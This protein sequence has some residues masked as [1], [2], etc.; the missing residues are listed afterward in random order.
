MTKSERKE[1]GNS[2]ERRRQTRHADRIR[3][4]TK[5]KVALTSVARFSF[6]PNG[7][8]THT[9]A[10]LLHAQGA[11]FTMDPSAHVRNCNMLLGQLHRTA[12]LLCPL[13]IALFNRLLDAVSFQSLIHIY[14]H[15]HRQTD[16][17][18]DRQTQA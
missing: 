8:F 12:W 4:I 16:T 10:T 17:D 1:T 5:I 2:L 18:I 6:V 15:R 3:T 14:G 9:M 13:L 7:T 11:V